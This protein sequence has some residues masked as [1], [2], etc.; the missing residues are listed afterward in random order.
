MIQAQHAVTIPFGQHADSTLLEFKEENGDAAV[1][2]DSIAFNCEAHRRVY[3]GDPNRQGSKSETECLP[4]S[5]V[6]SESSNS[7]GNLL[8]VVCCDSFGIGTR[9]DCKHS[10]GYFDAKSHCLAR[11]RPSA[12]IRP[13]PP[14]R[15][16]PAELRLGTAAQIRPNSD[17][18]RPPE[19]GRIQIG[20]DRPNLA[21][22]HIF[23]L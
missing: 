2:L 9:P 8:G 6:T 18:G 14:V 23:G 4:A 22:K 19:S 10:L 1:Q 11:G 12:R 3:L 13:N 16:N 7:Y 21:E 17:L 5:S 20:D 15:P